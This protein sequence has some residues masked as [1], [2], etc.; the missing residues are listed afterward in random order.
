MEVAAAEFIERGYRA[1]S[2][3]R[4]AEQAGYSKGAVYSNFAGK[5]ELVL[6][7]LD[8][9]FVHRLDI[10]QEAFQAAPETLEARLGV[11]TEWWE[12]M[13]GEQEW[14][15]LILEFASATRD[16]PLIQEQ[17]AAREHKILW[18][19]SVLIEAEAERFDLELPL[20]ARELSSVLVAL[21]TGLA[22]S[23]MLEPTIPI[24]VLSDLARIL[25]AGAR[26]AAGAPSTEPTEVPAGPDEP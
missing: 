6:A 8:D 18:F 24:H 10:L 5:E 21:G 3:E 22:F 26:P 15:V 16:R 7:L 17:L 11:F 9:H 20:T 19:V 13:V 1:T 25:F 12:D 4:V 2:L 14:G 23:R